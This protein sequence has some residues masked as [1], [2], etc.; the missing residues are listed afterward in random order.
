MDGQQLRISQ[1]KQLC[2]EAKKIWPKGMTTQDRGPFCILQI[3]NEILQHPELM[4]TFL[5]G[6]H[7]HI[8]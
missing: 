3:M 8:F 1:E 6:N 5:V 7:C 2:E 4:D